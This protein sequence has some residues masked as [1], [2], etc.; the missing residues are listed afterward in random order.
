MA[1][2]DVL[3]DLELAGKEFDKVSA[4]PLYRY[5][6]LTAS[7]DAEIERMSLHHAQNHEHKANIKQVF[8]AS[9]A[10]TPTLSSNYDPV[11]LNPTSRKCTARS[12]S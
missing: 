12:R 5:T 6:E 1:E 9:S 3:A 2:E 10:S 4:A 7:Q 11:Y 8:L